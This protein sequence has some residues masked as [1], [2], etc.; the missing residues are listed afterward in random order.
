MGSVYVTMMSGRKVDLL[1]FKVEDVDFDDI[2]YSLSRSARFADNVFDRGTPLTVAEHSITVSRLID[3]RYALA[4]LLHDAHEAYI[5]DVIT[6]VVIALGVPDEMHALKNHIQMRIHE[7]VGLPPVLNAAAQHAVSLADNDA[8]RRENAE[9]FHPESYMSHNAAHS[10][11]EE[12]M[13]ELA[14]PLPELTI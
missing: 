1:N 7:A 4:G 14:L 8:F 2:I 10:N 11:F 13:I 9:R 3:Q 6:P 5:G 12:R